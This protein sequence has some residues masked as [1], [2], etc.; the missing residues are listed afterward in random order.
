MSTPSAFR[1]VP[2]ALALGG[3]ACLALATWWGGRGQEPLAVRSFVACIGG[4][5]LA[6]GASPLLRGRWPELAG[7]L[8]T[9]GRILAGLALFSLSWAISHR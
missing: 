3:A 7:P 4:S 9:A 5:L 2:I 6:L 8:Q 1:A